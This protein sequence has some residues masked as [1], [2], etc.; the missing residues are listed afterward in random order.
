MS[1]SVS[2]EIARLSCQLLP[3]CSHQVPSQ[4]CPFM[5]STKFQRIAVRLYV[6]FFSQV[7]VFSDMEFMMTYSTHICCEKNRNNSHMDSR[8]KLHF[9]A[10]Y[11][12]DIQNSRQNHIQKLVVYDEFV[13]CHRQKVL[14]P[15]TSNPHT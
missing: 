10:P 2:L 12:H 4:S 5:P 3:C 15:L 11:Q 8:L 6:P 9:Y 13:F 1:L 7:S 14:F